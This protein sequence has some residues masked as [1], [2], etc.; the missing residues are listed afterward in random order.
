MP[1][2]FLPPAPQHTFSP[3]H[4]PLP[5]YILYTIFWPFISLFTISSSISQPS[6]ATKDG[7]PAPSTARKR[8]VI[9]VGDAYN[10][11][12][13]LTGGGMTVGLHDAAI[14]TR[15]LGDLAAP[16][17]WFFITSVAARVLTP[18]RRTSAVRGMAKNQ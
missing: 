10:M 7:K 1:N 14:L 8:G 6:P 13:P 16:K 11:R 2:S 15:L 18:S 9:L 12:H 3:S 5:L 17:R 4:L